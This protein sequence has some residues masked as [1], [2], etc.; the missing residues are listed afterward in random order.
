MT[1][2]PENIIKRLL[3]DSEDVKIALE[4]HVPNEELEADAQFPAGQGTSDQLG[5]PTQPKTRII[6][7]I[8]H[9]DSATGDEQAWYVRILC[10]PVIAVTREHAAL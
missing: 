3:R 8:T 6:A 10:Y 1:E 7:V 4:T 5:E 2:N 9:L